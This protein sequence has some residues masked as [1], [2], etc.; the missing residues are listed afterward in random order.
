[1]TTELIANSPT[2]GSASPI[3]TLAAAIT[4][5]PAPGT[6]ET[7]TTNAAAAPALQ[8][9]QFRATLVDTSGVP[10]EIILVMSGQNGT[11][12]TITRGV[13]G[14]TPVAHP[15]GASIYH[16]W[17]AAGLAGAIAAPIGSS[18]QSAII[19]VNSLGNDSLTGWSP[20]NAKLTLAAAIGA[21]PSGGGCVMVGKGSVALGTTAFDAPASLRIQGAHRGQSIITCATDPTAGTPAFQC[22][23]GGENTATVISDVTIGGPLGSSY[24]PSPGVALGVSG[25][26]V[27]TGNQAVLQRVNVTGFYANI[28]IGSTGEALHDVQAAA[29]W[30]NLYFVNTVAQGGQYLNKLQLYTAALGCIGIAPS[31]ANM[32]AMRAIGVGTGQAPYGLYVESHTGGAIANCNLEISFE[33]IGNELVHDASPGGAGAPTISGTHWRVGEFSYSSGE[34]AAGYPSLYSFYATMWNDVTFEDFGGQYGLGTGPPGGTAAFGSPLGSSFCTFDTVPH[35][36]HVNGTRT[37]DAY[38]IP[39]RPITNFVAG[40][41]VTITPTDDD[42]NLQTVFTFAAAGAQSNIGEGAP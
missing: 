20:G 4:T 36:Q 42:A 18:A 2:L 15:V 41:N 13:E 3:T 12:W 9:G 5:T 7:C 27:L 33:S 21:L 29:G 35:I 40:P 32:S 17:T 19:Y 39:Q 25:W 6:V 30:Y 26:G 38:G 34:K 37:D 23:G 31:G 24:I 1:M 10:R 16:I 11:T 8:G 28:C 14:S 22:Y